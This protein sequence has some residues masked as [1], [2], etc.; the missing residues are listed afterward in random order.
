MK[1]P[2][3]LTLLVCLTMSGFALAADSAAPVSDSMSLDEIAQ[4]LEAYPPRWEFGDQRAA[5][6]ASL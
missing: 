5:I 1:V 2:L 3:F 6:T 4:A